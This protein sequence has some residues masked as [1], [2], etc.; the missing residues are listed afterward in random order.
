MRLYGGVRLLDGAGPSIRNIQKI[1]AG[2]MPMIS[3]MAQTGLMIDPDHFAKMDIELTNDMERITEEIKVLTGHYINVSSGDQVADLLFKKLKLHQARPKFTTS[4]DRESVEDEVLTAIQHDHPVVPKVLEYKEFDKLRG[5]YVRPIPKLALRASG[6]SAG[7]LPRLYPNFSTT[8]VPSGRLACKQP[9]LLAMP[10]RTSRGRDIRKGFVCPEGWSY[11]AVDESQIEVRLA[12]H[13][14]SD[15]D[16]LRVYFNEEDVYSDFAITS[17]RLEDQRFRDSS[18]RWRYPTVKALEHRYP[19]KTCI[20]ASIYDVSAKGLLE[21]MPVVCANCNL[22]AS[23]HTCGRFVSYWTEEKCQALITSFYMKYPGVMEDRKRFHRMARRYGFVWDMWG[24]ILHVA[25]VR[26]V[27]PWVV[28]GALRE[29]GNFPYQSGAQGTVKLTMAEVHDAWLACSFKEVVKPQLQIHDELLFICRDDM[30][31]EWGSYVKS[32]F[33]N[34]A[35]LRVPIKA[36]VASAKNWG[37][38]DK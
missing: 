17:F 11:V 35:P 7:S 25:A 1:D 37:S 24:R 28:S 29:V 34:V 10:S 22:E 33:E 23:S 18:G 36:G 26:S 5:T 31:E 38:L 16:L 14:S 3:E 8:R 6:D 15:P 19:A 4:G 21:Q 9:N 27:L 20:L 13:S 12:A 32:V 30:V 2:A